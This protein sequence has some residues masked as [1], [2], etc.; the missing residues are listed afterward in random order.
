MPNHKLNES[1]KIMVSVWSALL[2]LLIASP[3][4]FKLTG[5]LFSQVGLSTHSR[6][7]PKM[8]GLVI[9]AVVFGLLVRLMMTV[10]VPETPE[11]DFL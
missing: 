8:T 3:F 10:P 9:H 6:G 7:C 11:L 4:M 5:Q 1:Q 2:F